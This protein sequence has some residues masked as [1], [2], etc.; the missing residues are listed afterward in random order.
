MYDQHDAAQVN[1]ERDFKESREQRGGSEGQT[2]ARQEAESETSHLS[3]TV[4]LLRSTQRFDS[5][6]GV[7]LV[8]HP[9]TSLTV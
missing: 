6:D 8:T 3:V 9:V 7:A 4:Y 2:P 5:S 1:D